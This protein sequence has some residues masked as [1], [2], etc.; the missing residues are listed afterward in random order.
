LLEDARPDAHWLDAVEHETAELA[1]AVASQRVETMRRLETVLA[2]RKGSAF[3]PAEI[4][5]DGWM[6]QLIPNHPAAEIEE[7]YRAVL[8]DNRPRDAAAGR[9]LDGPHLT[10]LKVIYAAKGTPAADASTGEQKALLIG[11]ILAHAR[12]IAE[13]S[14]FAPI[15]LLD[16]VVA[17]LDPS[18]RAAL[19]SELE[20]L[21]TQVFMTGADPALFVE[22][23]DDAL[24]VEVAA[25][26]LGVGKKYKNPR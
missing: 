21:G 5:L 19:H 25:G 18:R 10:D 4:A 20:Q 1:V 14:R 13:M 11:L 9:T 7:R 17:H 24:F 26:R 6:E 15:L 3:P 23:G 16:E 2:S 12:L 22:V 8:R